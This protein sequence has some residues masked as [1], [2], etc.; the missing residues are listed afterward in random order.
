MKRRFVKYVILSIIL[1]LAAC[2]KKADYAIVIPKDASIVA[3]FDF[4][5]I[6]T[7]SGLLAKEN[8]QAKRTFVESFEKN[9]AEVESI[10][11]FLKNPTEMGIDFNQKAFAFTHAQ[12]NSTAMVFPVADKD[13]LKSAFLSFTNLVGDAETFVEEDGYSWAFGYSLCI[14]MNDELCVIVHNVDENKESLKH[15]VATWLTHEQEA[16]FLSS[17]YFDDLQ[18]LKGEVGVFAS[19][20]GL[21]VDMS[22]LSNFISSDKFD[23]SDVSHLV[24]F[25]FEKGRI[26]VDSRILYK[27]SK[28]RDWLSKQFTSSK[29]LNAKSLAKLP[30]NTPFWFAIG[31]DGKSLYDFLLEHPTYGKQVKNLN[32]AFDFEDAVCSI[33]GDCALAYPY[34]LFLDVKNDEILRICVRTIGSLGRLVGLRLGEKQ[35]NQ[36]ELID[37]SHLLKRWLNLDV[38]LNMGMKDDTFYLMATKDSCSKLSNENTLASAPWASDVK[39]NLLFFMVNF[40]GENKL[41]DEYIYSR[42]SGKLIENYLSYVSYSQKDIKFNR[43]VVAFKNQQL[44][45]LQQMMDMLAFEFN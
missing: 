42:K 16:S 43:I 2:G 13:K 25:S 45:A 32:Y 19:N 37:D 30:K 31:I 21:P 38:N 28:L 5:R 11:K 34:G 4:Q 3:T 7:E 15:I 24:D 44:N 35:N 20:T 41:L 33:E 8:N 23:L 9:G 36:Y 18:N 40:Q 1:L 29:K 39:G 12:T 26:V 14:A 27:D 22:K 17:K 10:E 6:F